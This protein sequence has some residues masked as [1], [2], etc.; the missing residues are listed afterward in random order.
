MHDPTN[1]VFLPF[2]EE[3]H[4]IRHQTIGVKKKWEAGL[5]NLKNGKKL[6]II[7]RFVEDDLAVITASY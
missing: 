5:L 1:R 4:M 6:R 7:S 3:M 2:D